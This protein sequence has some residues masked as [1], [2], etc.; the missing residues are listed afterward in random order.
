MK[1][2]FAAWENRIAPVFDVVR[3]IHLVETEDGRVVRETQTSLLDELPV[4][5]ALRLAEM[6]VATLVCGAI[7]RSLRE[8][9]GA[10]GIQVISFVAGDLP[11]VIEAWLNGNLNSSAFTMPGCCGRRSRS[12]REANDYF[13]EDDA[14][15]R[16]GGGMGQGGGQGKGR[17]GQRSGRMGGSFAAGPGGQCVC[18]KCGDR[19]PH[20]R[21]V[22][23][24]E[25]KCPKCGTAMTRE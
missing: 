16:G 17:G 10:Y 5:R 8:L 15:R 6:G 2:A 18:P 21:G 22:P 1:V 25:V 13:E 19:V 4:Q 3:S 11:E 12:C 9:V 23:C 24:I 7:S 14:M 20:E